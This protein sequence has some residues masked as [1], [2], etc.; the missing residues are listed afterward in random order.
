MDEDGLPAGV[1]LF[2][3]GKGI[4]HLTEGYVAAIGLAIA[5][6]TTRSATSVQT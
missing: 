4:G 2:Q 3:H 5:L 1:T 6:E